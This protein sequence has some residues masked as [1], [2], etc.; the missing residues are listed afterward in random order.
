MTFA[1]E[2]F[3]RFWR[4]MAMTRADVHDQRIRCGRRT[5]QRF[6]EARINRLPNHMFDDGSVRSRC[7]NGHNERQFREKRA[8][9]NKNLAKSSNI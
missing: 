1:K 4:K 3:D 8:R 6:A 2:R 5:G 7:S 9:V